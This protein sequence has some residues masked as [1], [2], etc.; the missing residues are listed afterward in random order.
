VLGMA[1]KICQFCRSTVPVEATV[2][3]FCQREIDTPESA[4][5]AVR[6]H[7][8]RLFIGVAVVIIGGGLIFGSANR[9]TTVTTKPNDAQSSASATVVD[10]A[11]LSINSA[12]A[13]CAGM[14]TT[15]LLTDECKVSVW[16]RSVDV[17]LDL[18][19]TMASIFCTKCV[20]QLRG[21]RLKFEPGWTLRIYS[22]Y[23][24]DRT[25]AFCDI[26]T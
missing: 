19:S 20:E 2:C 18:T 11:T 13:F 17:T 16:N 4:A 9:T 3:R 21:T 26:R 8:K 5:A 24:G 6:R 1:H 14:K 12:H 10:I 22:P 7:D 23:S 15:G 25:V